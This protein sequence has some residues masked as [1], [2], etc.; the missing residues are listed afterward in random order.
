MIATDYC[1]NRRVQ[2]AELTRRGLAVAIALVI[3]TPLLVRN[4]ATYG[5]LTAEDIANIPEDWNSWPQALAVTTRYIHTSFWATSGIYNNIGSLFPVAGIVLSYVAIA[6][7]AWGVLSNR[8]RFAV[9]V[10]SNRK[11]MIALIA[12]VIANLALV[13]RFGLLY[14]Q[15]QGR[16]LFPLIRPISVLMAVGLRML[17]VDR[18][19]RAHLHVAGFFV[20]YATSFVAFSLASFERLRPAG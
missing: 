4:L 1:A 3:W 7:V 10:G 12:A 18:H 6:G 15:G 2:W 17:S 19:S 16:F 5:S 8:E 9:V 13:A 14:G 11:V 20:T